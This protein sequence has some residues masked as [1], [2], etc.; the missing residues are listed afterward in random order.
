MTHTIQ[1]LAKETVQNGLQKAAEQC[2]SLIGT[3]AFWTIGI[4]QI[5]Q[6]LGAAF[7]EK[8]AHTDSYM[9]VDISA[10]TDLDKL[11]DLVKYRQ[12]NIHLHCVK[13]YPKGTQFKDLTYLLHSKI[14]LFNLPDGKAKLWLGSHNFT[15]FALSGLNFESSVLIETDQNSEL[16]QNAKKYIENIKKSLGVVEFDPNDLDIYKL[17]RRGIE[18]KIFLYLFGKDLGEFAPNTKIR[19]LLQSEKMYEDFKEVDKK[20]TLFL[21]YMIFFFTQ[22]IKSLTL[23]QL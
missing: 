5:E 1:F 11:H 21:L 13:F 15:Q 16:Y 9:C 10:P 6:F 19:V 20:V 7:L 23:Y 3:V 17:L 12:S 14:V 2:E 8:L 22:K 18:E 4:G